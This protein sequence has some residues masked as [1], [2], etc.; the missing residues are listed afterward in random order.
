MSRTFFI[1]VLSFPYSGKLRAAP[2][3][4]FSAIR[5]IGISIGTP[6]L[7]TNLC[8]RNKRYNKVGRQP[9]GD[10]RAHYGESEITLFIYEIKMKTFLR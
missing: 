4:Y 8:T 7:E 5:I 1:E 2:R 6:H 10:E 9:R 3:T